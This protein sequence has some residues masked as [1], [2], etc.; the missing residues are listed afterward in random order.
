MGFT[1][2]LWTFISIFITATVILH[3]VTWPIFIE[4]AIRKSSKN[5]GEKSNVM[6]RSPGNRVRN[7]L[8]RHKICKV[9]WIFTDSLTSQATSSLIPGR[10]ADCI[11]M[12]LGTYLR[13]F[14]S[15]FWWLSWQELGHV[16]HFNMLQI[17]GRMESTPTF[18][19]E[20]NTHFFP[21]LFF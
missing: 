10:S 8:W 5:D 9:C 12:R 21:S 17:T 15:F 19:H 16:L 7:S 20:K 3:W 6:S 13:H 11:K 4:I 2:F 14:L 18:L 1:T